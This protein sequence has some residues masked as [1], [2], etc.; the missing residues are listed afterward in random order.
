MAGQSAPRAAERRYTAVAGVACRRSR[1]SIA[2]AIAG[3][4]VGNKQRRIVASALLA[5]VGQW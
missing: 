4:A 3:D 1:S 2:A 5:T